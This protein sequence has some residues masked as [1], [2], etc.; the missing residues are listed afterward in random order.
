MAE[1]S[2]SGSTLNP[3]LR[4]GG[5]KRVRSL[6]RKVARDSVLPLRGPRELDRSLAVLCR[7]HVLR[8]RSVAGQDRRI[9]VDLGHVPLD[10]LLDIIYAVERRHAAVSRDRCVRRNL[11]DASAGALQFFVVVIRDIFFVAPKKHHDA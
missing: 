2:F 9:G 11:V 6:A 7:Q 10:A 4:R 1:A 5:I 3:H 8:E